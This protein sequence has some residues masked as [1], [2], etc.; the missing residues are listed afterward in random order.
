VSDRLEFD[1]RKRGLPEFTMRAREP[2]TDEQLAI[3]MEICNR[4]FGDPARQLGGP[5]TQLKE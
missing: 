1:V 2:F 3:A 5:R 4:H